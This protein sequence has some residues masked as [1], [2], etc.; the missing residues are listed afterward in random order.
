W[1]ACTPRRGPADCSQPREQ[2]QQKGPRGPRAPTPELEDPRVMCKDCG[3]FRHTAR[4]IRCPMKCWQGALDPSPW[5][6]ARGAAQGGSAAEVSQERPGRQPQS[7]KELPKACDSA[8]HP[9]RPTPVYT[10]KRTCILDPRMGGW[11]HT[12]SLQAQTSSLS[13]NSPRDPHPALETL[14]VDFKPLTE[15]LGE[16]C[17][18]F[19]EGPGRVPHKR[20]RLCP[21][22]SSPWSPGAPELGASQ[23]LHP[24]PSAA[25]P[26][27]A[28][29]GPRGMPAQGQS[30][31][32]PPAGSQ[33][34][35]ATAQACPAP[36]APPAA[37]GPGLPLRMVFTRSQESHWSFRVSTAPSCP[38]PAT[39]ALLG[40]SLPL[41]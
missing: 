5:A 20:P 7:Q 31:G 30:G 18:Q 40:S 4:S 26:A 35:L 19:P 21:L 34:C 41:P 38:P 2:R 25:G 3:A 11:G 17:A 16:G 6:P 13:G 12:L 33:P 15:A 39:P 32:L 9:N 28:P 10:P 36:Q 37:Q 8:R 1:R 23:S 22:Q 27:A 14:A 29:Q 24:P